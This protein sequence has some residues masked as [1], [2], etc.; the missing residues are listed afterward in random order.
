MASLMPCITYRLPKRIGIQLGAQAAHVIPAKAGTYP[1][2]SL[3]QSKSTI[4][5]APF[6]VIPA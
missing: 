2:P 4:A 3:P 1:L 6:H 5:S